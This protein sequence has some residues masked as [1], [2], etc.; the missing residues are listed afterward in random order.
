MTY[1]LHIT[2][3]KVDMCLPV[4][5]DDD[6]NDMQMEEEKIVS[7]DVVVDDVT[8]NK[9]EEANSKPG[10]NTKCQEKICPTCNKPGH[11]HVTSKNCLFPTNKKSQHFGKYLCFNYVFL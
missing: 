3:P 7:P 1:H 9:K 6:N 4:N 5:N 8:K 11:L 10:K 2:G